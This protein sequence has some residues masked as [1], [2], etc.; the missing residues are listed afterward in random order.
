VH[1][2]AVSFPFEDPAVVAVVGSPTLLLSSFDLAP[3]GYVIEEFFVAGRSSSYKL[4][5]APDPDGRWNAAP[6]E[7]AP[8]TT[9]VVVVRPTDR[10]KFNGTV[11]FE[12]LNVSAGGDSAP[13]WNAAHR[14]MMR[15]GYVYAGVSAQRV[16]VEGGPS[17]VGMGIPLK[18]ADPER[19]GRLSHPGDVFAFDIFSQVGRLFCRMGASNILGPLVPK[20]LIAMGESQSAVFLTTYVNAVDP[21]AR[22]YDGFL[23]HSRFGNAVS[24]ENASLIPSTA[25]PGAVKLRTDLRAPVITVITETDLV[26]GRIPGFHGARQPDNERLRVWEVAGTSHADNYT[27]KV[28]FKDSGSTPLEELAAGYEPTATI[29]GSDLAKPINNA[30]QHHY[31]VEA[32]LWNLD[33]WIRTGQAP[34]EAAPIKL[35]KDDQGGGAVSLVLDA[36]GLAQGGVRT[37]WVDVPTARLSGVGNSGGPLGSMVGVCEPFDAVTLDRLYPGGKSMYLEKFEASLDSAIQAGFILL[38]DRQE[39]LDLAG[40]AFGA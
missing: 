12:W 19:Y 15:N 38:A 8:Y 16:G 37:P 17:L 4:S 24:L 21:L 18:R 40:I 7:T 20:R 35:S 23:I 2:S 32:V 28:G 31:V 30:P 26:G 9:R 25:Q 5:G 22:T 10:D 33:R 3:L 36:N 27:F 34:P 14:E 29:L 1:D 6:A 39:I 11:V 13:G